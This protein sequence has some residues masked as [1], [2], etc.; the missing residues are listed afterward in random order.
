MVLDFGIGRGEEHALVT[1]PPADHVW[2]RAV[3]P[4]DPDDLAVTILITLVAS[5]D[6]QLVSD[7][8]PHD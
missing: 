2:W 5:L 3:C 1:V 8:C 7:L 6:G 4:V